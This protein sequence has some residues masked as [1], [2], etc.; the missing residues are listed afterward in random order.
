MKDINT[1]EAVEKNIYECMEWMEN[2]IR[3][4]IENLM[5]QNKKDL[6]QTGN[7]L[8]CEGYYDALVDI[9]NELEIEM[10]N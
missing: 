6:K 5:E 7:N 3:D 4:I 8:Y 2:K 1:I 9:V 10:E